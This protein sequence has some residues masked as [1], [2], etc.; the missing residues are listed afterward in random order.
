MGNAP[1]LAFVAL[2]AAMSA[3]AAYAEDAPSPTPLYDFALQQ[4]LP[5]FPFKS[6]LSKE[7]AQYRA[8]L[9][10][11]SPPPASECAQTLGAPRLASLYNELATA[12]CSAGDYAGAVEAQQNAVACMP[13]DFYQ[14]ADLASELLH[15]GRFAQAREA[16]Q[17]ALAIRP[18]TVGVL[19]PL[20][21]VMAQLDFIDER[22]AEAV[23]RL[24]AIVVRESDERRARYRQL[25]LWLAQRRAGNAHPEL[26]E[27]EPTDE[28]FDQW[29]VFLLDALRG[30]YTE[31]EVLKAIEDEDNESRR[32]E[33]L[34]E[35][36][37]Y[38]GQARLADGDRETARRYF[39]AA[40]NLKVMHYREH[41]LALA[42]VLK[43]RPDG[44]A[45][46]VGGSVQS[47]GLQ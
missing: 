39:V 6:A 33:M 5:K 26:A 46:T 32:R 30:R 34:V 17:R 38:V 44:E 9:A 41:N 1:K 28:S 20:D 27:R 21:T 47:A 42:E 25:L 37:Y 12:L 40:V 22:W 10:R 8:E 19:T 7:I 15:A 45:G 4:P 29:P 14:H 31:H 16:A 24:R 23:A 43:M 35:A 36:L 18:A 2:V 11:Y 13:R 3:T